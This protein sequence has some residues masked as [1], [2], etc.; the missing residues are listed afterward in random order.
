MKRNNICYIVIVAVLTTSLLLGFAEKIFGLNLGGFS[1]MASW[2]TSP[3]ALAIGFVFALLFGE[4]YPKFH[5][6]E[7][8]A[9]FGCWSRIRYER[10]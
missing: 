3:V 10:I 8:T 6:E 5:V 2:V 7:A 9:V 1:W 4:A